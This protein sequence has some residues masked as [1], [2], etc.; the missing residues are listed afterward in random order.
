MAE[1]QLENLS[2][3]NIEDEMR[4]SY[5]DYAMSVIIGRA[6]PDVRDG[7]KPVHRRVLYTMHE[8]KSTHAAAY[9][10]SAR[11][12]GNVMGKYHPHGDAAIYDTIVRL[13]QDFSMRYM[14]VDGQG[15]FGS[16]DG[17]APAAMRYTEIRM[18][19]LAE[20]MLADIEKDTVNMTPNYDGSL[21]EPVVLPARA[22]NLLINGSAGIA[23]G[24]STSIPPHNLGEVVDAT[25]ALIKDPEIS[26]DEL[27]KIVPGPDFPTGGFIQGLSGIKSAYETGRGSIKMKAKASIEEG[28]KGT[29]PSIVVTEIP[30]QVNKARL[31]ERIAE[32]HKEK[33]IEGIRDL[34]DESDQR[35]MRIVIELRRDADPHVT[36]NRLYAMTA[37]KTSFSVILLAIVKGRPELL[38]LKEAL[39][40]FV[41]HRK[42]VVTRRTLFELR[43]AKDREHLLLGYEIALDNLDAVIDLIRKSSN[44]EDARTGLCKKF[45]LS[46]LQAKAILEM[47]LER[48]TRMERDRILEELKRVREKIAGLDKILGSEK[49]LM[50]LIVKEL[51]EIHDQYAD[52]R[53]TV[54]TEDEEDLS[55]EDLIPEED[56]VVTTSQQGFIKRTPV[57]VY[58]SQRRAGKGKVGMKMRDQDFV[59]KMFVTSTHT[60][61]LFFTNKGRVFRVRVYNIP[62]G[63]RQSKGRAIVNLL[64]VA[65]DEEVEAIMSVKD[66]EPERF[67]VFSTRKGLVKRTELSLFK[68]IRSN[69]IIAIKLDANDELISVRLSAPEEHVLLFSRKGKSIR[70]SVV[71]VRPTGRATRGVR[72]MRL[73]DNDAVVGMEILRPEHQILT[74]TERGYGK[75][76][77][78]DAYRFQRRAGT[79]VLAMKANKRV[80]LVMGMRSVLPSDE[81]LMTS[82]K[83]T[84]IRIRASEI[85]VIGRVTQGVRLMNMAKEEKVVAVD[86]MAEPE[87]DIVEKKTKKSGTK[88]TKKKG[89]AKAATKKDEKK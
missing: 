24:M 75:R 66:F 59:T 55:I 39:V 65:G 57:A 20:E 53:R 17:D 23:V 19:R 15:N 25:I 6:L 85:R 36:L 40:Q 68:N 72:G 12:V 3:I 31:L 56:M 67:L 83:G 33:R 78:E 27:M 45:G 11:I 60:W 34:R 43:K 7:L 41:E 1:D 44:P 54:I 69:G 82:N 42:D 49:V 74:V 50:D 38:N 8:T 61:L 63:S 35:G 14:L 71:D 70:F 13:A 37:L 28:T 10:K 80:G 84:T 73:K 52:K 58:Q 47:R 16:V 77:K 4:S 5:M 21:N 30:Y 64:Q 81:I 87:D 79:G 46:E 18:R 32:L 62:Q 76:T 2:L 29:I 48:L 88:K 89:K 86:V 51:K 22:P 26:I 9:K